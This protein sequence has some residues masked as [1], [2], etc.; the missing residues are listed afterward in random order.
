MIEQS[1]ENIHSAEHNN[2]KNK[3]K[4]IKNEEK[5]KILTEKLNL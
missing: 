3:G 2:L 4:N 1:E 5:K